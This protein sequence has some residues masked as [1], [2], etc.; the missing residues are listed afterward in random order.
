MHEL[1]LQKHQG[2]SVMQQLAE[3]LLATLVRFDAVSLARTQLAA[4]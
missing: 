4:E 2:F 1:T 3:T